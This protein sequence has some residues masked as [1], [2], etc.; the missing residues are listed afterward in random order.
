MVQSC[1]NLRYRYSRFSVQHRCVPSSRST[2]AMRFRANLVDATFFAK[3]LGAVE[4]VSRLCIVRLTE[5][6]ISVAAKP[7]AGDIEMW[8][9]LKAGAIFSEDSY[10]VESRNR[11]EI[12]FELDLANLIRAVR[13]GEKASEMVVKLSKK[14]GLPFW[15]IRARR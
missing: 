4:K 14:N 8:A 7:D 11:N 9:H 1:L 15:T 13:S 6:R 3:I 2:R 10:K 12:C 5:S